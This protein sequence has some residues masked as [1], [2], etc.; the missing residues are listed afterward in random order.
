MKTEKFG[1]AFGLLECIGDI[2]DFFLD[3]EDFAEIIINS[4]KRKRIVRYST[5]AAAASIGIAVT[6]WLFRGKQKSSNKTSLSIK[7][8]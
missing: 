2:S 1:G 5:F 4:V 7:S 6:Y 3:E 8:A